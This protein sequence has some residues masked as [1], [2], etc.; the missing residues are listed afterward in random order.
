MEVLR[1]SKL[2][3]VRGLF[4]APSMASGKGISM[5]ELAEIVA[6]HERGED[7]SSASASTATGPRSSKKA[8]V[9]AQYKRS[10][11]LLNARMKECTCVC[12]VDVQLL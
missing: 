8:T 6:A 2:P 11:E 12:R 1:G 10:L 7:D 4:V 9:G 5:R 3:V